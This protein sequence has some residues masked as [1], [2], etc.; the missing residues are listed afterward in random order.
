MKTP[1]NIK[2]KHLAI[3]MDGN[4]RWAK[5]NLLKAID[6]HKKGAAQIKAVAKQAVKQEVQKLSLYAFSSE[7]WNRSQE[8][9]NLL[10]ELLLNY[11][12]SKDLQEVVDSNIWV[13]I[14]G[15][16][17]KFNKEVILGIKNLE[18][19][20]QTTFST[21]KPKMILNIALNYGSRDE[22]VHA[23]NKIIK[24]N[25]NLTNI[26]HQD[27]AKNL[28]ETEDVDLL[29]RSGGNKRLSNFLLWQASYSEL[30]FTDILWPDFT[31]EHFNDAVEFFYKQKRN[32][33][34]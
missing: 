28:Y 13:K 33:G 16:I 11:L 30:Y 22:I 10:Q 18:E 25:Q 27:I 6:G 20:M 12:K 29:I 21:L 5:K 9:I 4:R 3:I 14:I 19:K 17:S 32:F 7:N 15:D 31:Q 1:Q 34:T 8:E 23:I 2:L 26:T 24:N